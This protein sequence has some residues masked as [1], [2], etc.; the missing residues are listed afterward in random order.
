MSVSDDRTPQ[1]GDPGSGAEPVSGEETAGR[2]SER[3][4]I[5]VRS[6]YTPVHKCSTSGRMKVLRTTPLLVDL[7]DDQLIEVDRRMT[8]F[9]ADAGTVIHHEGEAA[10][11]YFVLAAGRA[12]AY[13]L[14]PDGQQ[15]VV[16]F[17]GPGDSFGGVEDLGQVVF[18]ETVETLT[19]VCVLQIDPTGFHQL[20]E[21]F[22][23]V[24]LRVIDQ[25]STQLRAARSAVTQQATATVTQRVARQ[26]MSLRSESACR[27]RV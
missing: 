20:I 27:E 22:P 26:L 13:R 7:S 24:A 18:T 14:S 12:K 9:H 25:L 5:P 3:R 21:E 16:N 11:H 10:H 2:S 6:D 19:S 23:A 4:R 8:P 17:L 1:S 15:V